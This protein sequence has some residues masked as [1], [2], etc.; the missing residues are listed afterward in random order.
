M[1]IKFALTT[2]LKGIVFSYP[3]IFF[4]KSKIFAALLIL[5]TFI[6]PYT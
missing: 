2:I 4:S 5:L 6:D 3:N 1:K